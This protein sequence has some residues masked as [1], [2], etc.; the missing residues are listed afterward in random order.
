M[1][2]KILCLIP[3]LL[4]IFSLSAA[5][6]TPMAEVT[7]VATPLSGGL[8]QYEFTIANTSDPVGDAGLNLFFVALDFSVLSG[9]TGTTNIAMP[10]N[11][12]GVK[13]WDLITDDGTGLSGFIQVYSLEPGIPPVG[14]DIAPGDYLDGF[15]FQFNDRLNGVLFEAIMAKLSYDDNGEIVLS[16][17][18]YPEGSVTPSD[19]VSIPE[20]ATLALVSVGLAGMGLYTRRKRI[21]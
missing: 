9:V 14:A 13:S 2:R 21:H 4:L 6:A 8:W 20:P 5:W 17:F 3:A 10:T 1:R 7:Y 12:S 19:V 15:V 18:A 16:D 11:S